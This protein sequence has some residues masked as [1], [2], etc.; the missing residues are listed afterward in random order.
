MAKK[1]QKENTG[2]K[3]CTGK[4]CDIAPI[5]SKDCNCKK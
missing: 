3:K 4:W 1:K 2:N 5:L